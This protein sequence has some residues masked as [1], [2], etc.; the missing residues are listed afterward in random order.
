[1]VS[2][3]ARTRFPNGG[4]GPCQVAVS[5]D[6]FLLAFRGCSPIR[7]LESLVA[8]APQQ[9]SA[10]VLT[11]GRDLNSIERLPVALNEWTKSGKDSVYYAS[12]DKS[13]KLV[14]ALYRMRRERLQILY[15]NSF[16][17]QDCQ[18]CPNGHVPRT[19]RF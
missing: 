2:P 4:L 6:L 7:T 17:A 19:T 12:I 14:Q 3:R 5:A 8:S 9:F 13:V 18:S 16:L 1:M 15:L 11:G 10:S